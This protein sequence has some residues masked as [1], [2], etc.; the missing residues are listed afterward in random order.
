LAGEVP[1]SAP[2]KAPTMADVAALAGVSRALVSTVFRGVPGAGPVTR[3]RV[4]EAAA[5]L[6]YK[7]DNRARLLRSNRTKLVGVVFRAQDVF[8]ADLVEAFY[9]TALSTEYD[10]V[11]SA[12]TPDRPELAAAESL[13]NDRCEALVL[14][15]PQM[16]DAEL[17]ALGQRSPTIV[18]ARRVKSAAV[19]VVM[20]ADLEV[21][22]TALEHLVTLG[23]RDIAHLD[24][25]SI[26]GATDRRRSYRT[27]MR[28]HGLAPYTRI[29][30]GGNTEADGM[31]VAELVLAEPNPPTA[32]IA[33]NDRSAVGLM[34]GL[35]RAGVRVPDDISVI[36]YDDI[37]M[38]ALPFIDLTTVGQDATATARHA[39]KHV[40]GRLEDNTPAGNQGF[41]SPY[42]AVR[43][44]TAEPTPSAA[45]PAVGRV[46]SS[47]R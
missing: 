35:Q 44:T 3:Q 26:H 22:R 4:L 40:S 36:G 10:L 46:G 45:A 31:R 5:E 41:V 38:A 12:T 24:G 27:L 19:D 13:L 43:S 9:K 8:H 20:T 30:P 17:T 18:V 21:V 6:G 23:H 16:P 34:F 25:G 39:F 14:V 47:A 2:V 37:A 33:F 32:V 7:V 11:L 15:S 28:R 1:D 29:Y 42:L